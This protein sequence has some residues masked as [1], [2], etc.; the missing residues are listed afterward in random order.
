MLIADAARSQPPKEIRNKSLA[1]RVR[2][3]TDEQ[4]RQLVSDYEA[5]D[6]TYSLAR[7]FGINRHTV[8]EHLRRGAIPIHS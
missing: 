5:G 6:S 8:S 7:R 3:L 2:K 4:V 1:A